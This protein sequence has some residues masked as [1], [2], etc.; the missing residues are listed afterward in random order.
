MKLLSFYNPDLRLGVAAE[1][2]VVD[3]LAAAAWLHADFPFTSMRALLEAGAMEG[4]AILATRVLE[5]ASPPEGLVL[6]EA[7]I[8]FAPPVPDA[9]KV[10][11][12][13]LNY[14]DHAEENKLEPPASP[15][16]FAKLPQNLIG[17]G[18]PIVLPRAAAEQ[19]DYEAEFAVVI[20][21]RAR[22]VSEAEAEECIAGYTNFN[23]V[24]AR[25]LQFADKQWFRGKSCDTFAPCGPYLVPRAGLA[26]REEN[27]G[28]E[29]RLNGRAL[30]RSNTGNLFFRVPYL[31]SFLSQTLT[32]EAGDILS[33]G[34]PGGV[35]V[36]RQ[37]PVFLRPGDVVEVETEGL[38]ILRNPVVAEE[39]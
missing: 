33:T 2:R 10:L 22:R 12:V 27:L 4:A 18:Q 9:G 29:L 17:H 20:G 7:A 37:P 26:G 38:G 25:D 31:I 3:L 30:Q 8:R 32:L 6:E 34:T 36:F 24:T 5:Q 1:G 19:V 35:G 15:L 13:G 16:F 28:L 23:D 39:P 14:R 11:C 21:R